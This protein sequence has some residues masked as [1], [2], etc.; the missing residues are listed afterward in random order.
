MIRMLTVLHVFY[1]DQVDYFIDKLANISGVEWDLVVTYTT[2]SKL[3]EDKFRAFKPDARMMEV[4][5]IGYDVWPF[6]QVITQTEPD[7]YDYVLKLHT[8]GKSDMR[9][10]GVR[11]KEWLWR[12]LMVDALIMSK[13]RFQTCIHLLE[14]EPGIGMLCSYELHKDLSTLLAEDFETITRESERVSLNQISGHFCAGTIFLARMAALR[15]LREIE[16]NDEMWG[17]KNQSHISGT[18]AHAYERLLGVFMSED[19]Y[20]VVGMMSYIGTSLVAFYTNNIYAFMRKV[21]VLDRDSVTRRKRLVL[22]GYEFKL[23]NDK[24]SIKNT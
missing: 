10:N 12:D 22:F 19:G 21:F 17:L 13:T 7:E 16:F 15:K 11:M 5:N 3:T 18:L 4:K 20:R 23:P 1:H 2:Y 6:I 9:V 14:K 24:K 8:K